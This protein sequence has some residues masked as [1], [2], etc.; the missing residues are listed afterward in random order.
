L[1]LRERKRERYGRRSGKVR[2]RGEKWGG[3][4]KRGERGRE[5]MQET[6]IPNGI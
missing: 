4:L 5:R 1:F 6:R 2:W 3:F